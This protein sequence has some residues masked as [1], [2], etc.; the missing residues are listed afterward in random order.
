MEVAK[1]WAIIITI[2]GATLAFALGAIILLLSLRALETLWAWIR[3]TGQFPR[4]RGI[5]GRNNRK[6]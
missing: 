5:S 1:I 2:A 4:F 6:Q 3:G